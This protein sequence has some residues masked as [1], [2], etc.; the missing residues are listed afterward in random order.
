MGAA[1]AAAAEAAAASAALA[2]RAEVT[3]QPQAGQ[4]E[5]APCALVS[6]KLV[7]MVLVKAVHEHSTCS[8]TRH[9]CKV[10]WGVLDAW[11]CTPVCISQKSWTEEMLISPVHKLQLHIHV[12]GLHEVARQ[13]EHLS[14]SDVCL[15]SFTTLRAKRIFCTTDFA[16]V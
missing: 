14:Q 2:P 8:S 13:T 7:S 9:L 10:P 16:C 6:A 5:N 12:S 4:D 11:G 15:D 1:A 3:L